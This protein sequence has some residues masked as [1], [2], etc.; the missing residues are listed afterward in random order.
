MFCQ[1]SKAGSGCSDLYCCILL[2][3]QKLSDLVFILP[4][5]FC[6]QAELLYGIFCSDNDSKDE[7][8]QKCL[9]QCHVLEDMS[10]WCTVL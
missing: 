8:K 4:N 1:V 7:R 9:A 10:L 6:I 5:A 2:F 3:D